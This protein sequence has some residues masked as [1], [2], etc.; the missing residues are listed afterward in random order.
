MGGAV[1]LSVSGMAEVNAM[2]TFATPLHSRFAHVVDHPLELS[3]DITKTIQ[4]VK[5][6]H[7]IHGEKDEIVPLSHARMLHAQASNP[8]KLTVQPGGDHRMSDPVHQEAF[9]RESVDWYTTNFVIEEPT[10]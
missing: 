1:C 5:N 2:I 4:G 8:K 10:P 6:I 3:F 9:I 7:I